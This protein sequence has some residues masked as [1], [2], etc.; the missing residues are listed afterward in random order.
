M[1]TKADR[2]RLDAAVTSFHTYYSSSSNWG[3]ERW[4]DSLYPALCQPTRYAAMINQYVSVTEVEQIL[5]EHLPRGQ[6]ISRVQLPKQKYSEPASTSNPHSNLIILEH[7]TDATGNATPLTVHPFP[8]PTPKP[9]LNDPNQLLLS[10]WNLDAAS[11]ICAHML[12][13]HPGV[14]VLDLCAAPGGKSIAL[15]QSLFPYSTTPSTSTTPSPTTT[16]CLHSNELDA[17]RAR[18]LK[19][20][21]RSYLPASLFASGHIQT[22]SIDGTDAKAL[23]RFPFGQG[24]YDRVLL[25]APCSSERHIIHAQLRAAASG[26]TAE[27]MARWRPGSSRNIAKTQ[28]ALLMVAL[29]AVK[30]GGRVVYSTCSISTEENDGVVEKML[31]Q[32]GKERG[33]GVCNWGVRVELGRE[34]M[35]KASGGGEWVGLDECSEETRFG[36]I[37]VPDHPGGGGWGPLYF[38]V[39]TKV[40]TGDVEV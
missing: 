26:H 21:L 32:V 40:G 18:R 39:L 11:A 34:G 37:V 6:S 1:P 17:P 25:D 36:R 10:H 22:F 30:V 14:R 9:S 12:D 4:H 38:A 28:L 31:V 7:T 23:S 24:G 35:G 20:N 15:A 5:S 13:I 29:G 3:I 8:P 16:S 19:N 2:K 27:E 33:K